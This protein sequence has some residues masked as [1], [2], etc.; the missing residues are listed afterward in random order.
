MS[1]SH[2]VAEVKAIGQQDLGPLPEWDLADLYPGRGS[3]ELTRDLAGLAAAAAA[4]RARYQGRLGALPGAELG[5]A[6]AEYERLQEVAG[7][8]MSYAELMRAGNVAD[9]E[10]ARFFQTMHERIN[11]IST[12]LLF[13]TLEINRLEDSDLDAKSADPALAHYRPWL[14]DVP[15]AAPAPALGRPGKAA[16]REIGG[17]A[18]RLDP[19]LRRDDRRAALSVPRPRVDRAR[20][21]A[22][23]LRPRRRG[24]V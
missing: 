1:K 14:R 3:P 13:F 9:P 22:P 15:G 17:R 16:A 7:R 20:G 2:D 19:P 12:E 8:V 4:F 10:I 23:P 24:A 21:D 11:A 18:R 6:V 5:A